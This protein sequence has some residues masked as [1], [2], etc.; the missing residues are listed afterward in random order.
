MDPDKRKLNRYIALDLS[1][2]ATLAEYNKLL[3]EGKSSFN[4]LENILTKHWVHKG[5]NSSIEESEY[6]TRALRML[7]AYYNDPLDLALDSL[8]IDKTL[9]K[10]ITPSVGITAKI[11]KLYETNNKLIELIDYKTGY[12]LPPMDKMFTT[13]QIPITLMLI[14][15]KY[16]FYPNLFSY[17]YLSIN[18]KFTLKIN[19]SFVQASELYLGE[20]INEIDREEAYY[21]CSNPCHNTACKYYELCLHQDKSK[22][23]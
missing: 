5:F 1:L 2:H 22:N 17:Y 20:I 21:G 9:K 19:N 4:T 10:I 16:G 12:T 3:P 18:R 6:R 23:N 8:V 14:H 15:S 13:I 11:D 7:T